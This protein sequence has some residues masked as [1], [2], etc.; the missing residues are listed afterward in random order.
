MTNLQALFNAKTTDCYGQMGSF[1]MPDRSS[2][3]FCTFSCFYLR[4]RIG[5]MYKR[6]ARGKDRVTLRAPHYPYQWHTLTRP[7]LNRMYIGWTSRHLFLFFAFSVCYFF[8][9]QWGKLMNMGL[10]DV[11]MPR[12]PPYPVQPV[13]NWDGHKR[14]H[15]CLTKMI[16]RKEKVKTF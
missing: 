1:L 15:C 7:Y 16:L 3:L 9:L 12:Y 6:S 11:M 8:Y 10:M 5:S 4:G 13:I 2:W 14:G